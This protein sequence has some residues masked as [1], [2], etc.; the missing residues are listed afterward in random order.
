MLHF[1]V[2][3]SRSD[4]DP[5]KV[6]RCKV[7]IMGLH[8]D[9]KDILKT[10]DLPWATP[11]LSTSSAGVDGIGYSPTG[12]VEGSWVAIQFADEF[13]QVPIIIGVLV[14]KPNEDGETPAS[15]DNTDS[16]ENSPQPENATAPGTSTNGNVVTDSSGNTVQS[17]TTGVPVQSGNPGGGSAV[18]GANGEFKAI[19]TSSGKIYNP[20]ELPLDSIEVA[21]FIG[22]MEACSSL[23]K[24]KNK[25]VSLSKM[26][27]LPG[28]TVLYPYWDSN[29]Y[30][31]AFGNHWLYEGKKKIAVT[32]DTTIPISRALPT[33]KDSIREDYGRIIKNAIRVPVTIQQYAALISI[34]YN[35]GGGV[36]RSNIISELNKGNYAGASAAIASY[37]N[38][39]ID[40]KTGARIS[41]QGRRDHERRLFDSGGYPSPTGGV[42][43]SPSNG[44]ATPTVDKDGAIDYTKSTQDG[45][46]FADR[47]GTYPQ[48]RNESAVNRLA[49]GSSQE[50]KKK[51]T[52]VDLKT[53]SRIKGVPIAGGGTW[54]QVPHGYAAKY[55]YNHVYAS[56]SGH[57][58]EYDDTYGAERIAQWHRAG[59]YYEIDS[60][61][62]KV[63]RIVG[64]NYEI[65]DRNGF[66]VVK[67]N[68]N[69]TVMGDC[70]IYSEND[71]NVEARG[72][73][74]VGASDSLKL[75]SGG[76]M[77]IV[78]GGRLHLEGKGD[79]IIEGSNTHIND[80]IKSGLSLPA[81]RSTGWQKFEQIIPDNRDSYLSSI[82]DD[83]GGPPDSIKEKYPESFGDSSSSADEQIVGGIY[84]DRSTP[85]T[86]EVNV[87]PSIK[88]PVKLIKTSKSDIPNS[89]I[90]LN[91][92]I[93]KHFKLKHFIVGD[94][95]LAEI[96][97]QVEMSRS[98][99]I[100]NLQALAVNCLD[101]IYE[102]Y[103]PFEVNSWY[104][105]VEF[106]AQLSKN[107]DSQASPVSQH[108]F[109]EALDFKF[110]DLKSLDDYIK[111]GKEIA[112]MNIPYHQLAIEHNS[113]G[114]RWLHIGLRS[115]PRRGQNRHEFKVIKLTRK[116]K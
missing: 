93:S 86:P 78:A 35:S 67:G 10:E 68:C 115:L 32:A 5:Y 9:D 92:Q 36:A 71:V 104:R 49:R 6:G 51:K 14:G 17:G 77:T 37:K 97:P 16:A 15:Y 62:T 53:A 107:P 83:V 85:P 21:E 103:G 112:A 80:G 3:E 30:A 18:P 109:G 94:H 105:T 40:K 54:D 43:K 59:T 20:S 75:A 84:K 47:T 28:N 11:L 2:V 58:M 38:Y 8:T 95:T 72:D 114:G 108:L 31:I 63:T 42:T 52:I 23:T 48:Y 65:L 106:N 82:D 100:R 64:D 79:C 61:G 101:P 33:L 24:G 41:L 60:N 45:K 55:P 91:M 69:I 111:R 39:A 50:D 19:S 113:V 98:D 13:K 7:R 89:D 44:G 116:K 74:A 102:K 96:V 76:D 29:G 27:T 56:E 90:H 46:S 81:V 99:I 70:N 66:L 88:S 26:K 73:V 25:H 22:A 87:Q 12:L 1:G 34:C 110:T 4:G 57:V